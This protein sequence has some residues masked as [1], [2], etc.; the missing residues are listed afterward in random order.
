[1]K[2]FVENWLS[3][4]NM[5]S[6]TKNIELFEHIK[7]QT[8]NLCTRRCPNCYFGQ[9]NISPD[10]VWLDDKI[11]FN[12]IDQ[13]RI[14]GYAGRIGFFEINEPLTDPRMLEFIRFAKASLPQVFHMLISNGDLLDKK[15]FID[16]AENGLDKL[17]VSAYDIETKHKIQG[18]IRQVPD[19]A[20]KLEIMDLID[21]KFLDNRGGNIDYEYLSVPGEPLQAPCERVHKVMYVRPSGKVVSCV[22]D[23]YEVNEVGDVTESSLLDIWFGEKFQ[24]LRKNLD[25][26]NRVF[27]PLCSKCNYPG[28][29][30]YYGY[31]F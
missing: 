30:W 29:G 25:N 26:C 7:I 11:V 8:N 5:P 10:E 3:R 18:I 1:M 15:K 22:S 6:K 28:E 16:L 21:A 14:M 13:L 27:S 4:I 24:E 20:G 17:L 2:I 19:Y 9:K 12:L 23:F 31:N